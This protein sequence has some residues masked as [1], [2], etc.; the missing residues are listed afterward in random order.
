M[1]YNIICY[2]SKLDKFDISVTW[3]KLFTRSTFSYLQAVAKVVKNIY[4]KLKGGNPEE[5]WFNH[6]WK[7]APFEKNVRKYRKVKKVEFRFML[8]NMH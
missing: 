4:T 2:N 5:V 8:Q 1:Y 6:I 3:K 7:S